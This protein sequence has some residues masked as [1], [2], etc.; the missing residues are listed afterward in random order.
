MKQE[1]ESSS[2]AASRTGRE[3][4]AILALRMHRQ[5][6]ALFPTI[7]F[8]FSVCS[9]ASST[10]FMLVHALDTIQLRI[11]LYKKSKIRPKNVLDLGRQPRPLHITA[12][13]TQTSLHCLLFYYRRGVVVSKVTKR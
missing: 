5:G 1:R 4:T 3:R 9:D 2:E 12:F 8:I 6:D 7:T 10:S 13:H 11:S